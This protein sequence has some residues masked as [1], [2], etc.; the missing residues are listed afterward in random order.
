MNT[1]RTS[2][3]A[4]LL[5]NGKVLVTGGYDD[6]QKYLK[7]AELYDPLTETWTITG[8]MSFP[9]AK[10]TA[11]LLRNGKVLVSGGLTN[12]L[13]RHSTELYDVA[14][15]IWT[16]GN[17]MNQVRYFH[18]ATELEN[19]DMLVAGGFGGDNSAELYVSPK[20]TLAT[21]NKINNLSNGHNNTTGSNK[22]L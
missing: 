8:N 2:H 3:T 15:G 22:Y 12:S 5:K 6:T 19:G 20:K 9:R 13:I 17:N 11:S 21:I 7:S 1:Q 18:T 10:H 4:I 16:V 14:T